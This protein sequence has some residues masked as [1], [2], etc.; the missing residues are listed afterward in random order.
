ME[1]VKPFTREFYSKQLDYVL[2]QIKNDKERLL[3]MIMD[4]CSEMDITIPI[5]I[6]EVQR[7]IVRCEKITDFRIKNNS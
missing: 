4:N 6:N 5:K 7:Y 1:Q 3:D 2:E